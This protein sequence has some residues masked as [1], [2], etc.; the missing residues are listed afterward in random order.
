MRSY[1]NNDFSGINNWTWESEWSKAEVKDEEI[2]TVIDE[3]YFEFSSYEISFTH[4]IKNENHKHAKQGKWVSFKS[5][6]FKSEIN[7]ELEKL[8]LKTYV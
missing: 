1:S 2:L 4:Y 6:L 8:F 3:V 7:L 5:N